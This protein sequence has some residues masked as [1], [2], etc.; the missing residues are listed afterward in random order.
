MEA[1]LAEV[2]TCFQGRTSRMGEGHSG[3]VER[4]GENKPREQSRPGCV[5]HG[6]SEAVGQMFVDG[7]PISCH[8]LCSESLRRDRLLKV[9]P[10]AGHV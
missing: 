7:P 6:G 5:F 4:P 8:S 2:V 10:C 3:Q 1:V 9:A